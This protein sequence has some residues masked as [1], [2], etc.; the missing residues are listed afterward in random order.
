MKLDHDSFP[1]EFRIGKKLLTSSQSAL[2]SLIL[3]AMSAINIAAIRSRHLEPDRRR[4]FIIPLFPLFPLIALAMTLGLLAALPW[5]WTTASLLSLSL[6]MLI[7]KFYGRKRAEAACSGISY[8]GP[9]RDRT[10]DKDRYRILVPV[11]PGQ[12]KHIVLQLAL[13]LARQL[14][15]TLFPLQVIPI[16]D[17]LAIEEGQCIAS[18]PEIMLADY[19]IEITEQHAELEGSL[20][21]EGS[22]GQDFADKLRQTLEEAAGIPVSI[23]IHAIPVN[24][25]ESMQTASGT[26]G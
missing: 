20:Y 26:D 18:T 11:N 25:I 15:A 3:L 4:I 24:T 16:P 1:G 23:Q 19:D 17:P 7:Y 12:E 22:P 5:T 2:N 14:D 8:F 10:R 9:D 6:G 13:S 21:T